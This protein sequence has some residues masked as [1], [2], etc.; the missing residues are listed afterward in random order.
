MKLINWLHR[1]EKVR[2]AALLSGPIAW[3]VVAYLGAISALLI[4]SFFTINTF[5][6]DVVQKFNFG[7][8]QELFTDP[9]YRNVALRT[10]LVLGVET[11]EM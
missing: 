7:N 9:A 10:F 1:H 8:F 3:L 6:G 11:F 5:T 2:L 4:T